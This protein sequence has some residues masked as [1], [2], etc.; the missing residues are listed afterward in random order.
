MNLFAELTLKSKVR[1][2][3]VSIADSRPVNN[4][5]ELMLLHV[6]AR[7]QPQTTLLYRFYRGT[8]QQWQVPLP[9]GA[10]QP[11]LVMLACDIYLKQATGTWPKLVFSS[12]TTMP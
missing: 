4:L 12:W 5:G 11:I 9:C 1:H 10:T 3:R 8:C 2:T 6:R 7:F